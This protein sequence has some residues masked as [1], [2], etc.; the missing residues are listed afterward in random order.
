MAD[1]RFLQDGFDKQL[2][3]LIEECGEV[4]AAAAKT[5]RWGRDSVNPLL[6]PGDATYGETNEQWLRREL[7]D[8]KHVIDRLETTLIRERQGA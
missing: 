7:G 6:Q 4:V 5:Q 8:L 3:H 1:E 2:A